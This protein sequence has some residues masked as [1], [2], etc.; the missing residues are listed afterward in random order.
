MQTSLSEEFR[1][2]LAVGA[3]GGKPQVV[4][5]SNLKLD[6]E[7]SRCIDKTS[8][9]LVAV[10]DLRGGVE[11]LEPWN[12]PQQRDIRRRQP[13][14]NLPNGLARKLGEFLVGNSLQQGFRNVRSAEVP[15]T[16]DRFAD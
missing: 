16:K 8:S 15:S 6:V 3:T 5:N 2:E 4:D 13:E 12:F 7:S 10:K 1:A 9:W 11:V 14:V